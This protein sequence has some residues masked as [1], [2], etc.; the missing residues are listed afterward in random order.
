M[1]PPRTLRR[2][3]F[4]LCMLCALPAQPSQAAGGID[5]A[6]RRLSP[7]Q[8]RNGPA[9]VPARPA[10]QAA[11]NPGGA[12]LDLPAAIAL[13]VAWHPSIAE[14]VGNL[15]Q[16]GEGI[17]V[18]EAGYYPQVSGGVKA[19]V[20]SGYNGARGSRAL[21]LSLKQ[22]LYDFGKVRSGVDMAQAK[23]AQ[24]QA[25]ILLAIGQVVRDTAY[26]FIEV[27]RY[28]QL[29]A[30]ARQQVS[31]IGGIVA[32]ARQR[33]DL[34]ASTR[35]DVVQAQSRAD[36]AQALLQEYKA[37][38][39][40]WQATL[41]SLLGRSYVPALNEAPSPRLEGACT[42]TAPAG[43][44]QPAVL[45]ALAQRSEARA[46]LNQARAQAFPTLSLEPSVNHYLDNDYDRDNP[47]IDRTQAG[48]YLNLEVP[49][50]Q[51]GATSART[52]A[53]GHA[54]AAADSAEDAARLHARQGL[55]EA[56]AQTASLDLRLQSLQARQVSITEARGLYE[57]QYLDLGTRPLLDLLNAEQEI[58]QARFDLANTLADQQR[59]R[60]DCLYERG[61][62]RR[63]MGL[64]GLAVQGVEILP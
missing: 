52:R 22:M 30:I 62:L 19:G 43:D 55:A 16:Q 57:R 31:G 58:H 9:H 20:D 47:Y 23:A 10:P 37:Q 5:P 53:A 50:Y 6:W 44:T 56:Q 60:V 25:N 26:A 46:Q 27:C 40:R 63:A 61:A 1:K 24:A 14:A 64:E 35:S 59:L 11:D 32:L 49:I 4:A 38:L 34:G 54:L 15:Y 12:L 42:P 2:L 41:T 3:P 7:V 36:G 45:A 28:E 51:G 17:N 21:S 39:A 13:A 8:L 18:A 29:L 48:L 33:S